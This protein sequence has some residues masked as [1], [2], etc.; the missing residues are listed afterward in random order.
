MV[1]DAI[2]GQNMALDFPQ[3]VRY[4][5]FYFEIFVIYTPLIPSFIIEDYLKTKILLN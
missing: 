5:P 4:L 3:L 1:L 2:R